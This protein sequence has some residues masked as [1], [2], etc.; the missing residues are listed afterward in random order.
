MLDGLDGDYTVGHGRSYLRML[1]SAGRWNEFVEQVVRTSRLHEQADHRQPQDQLLSSPGAMLR[2]FALRELDEL[3]EAGR[4]LPVF[5]A[6][7]VLAR[8]TDLPA[9]FYLKRYLRKLIVPHRVHTLKKRM[10]GERTSSAPDLI[11]DSFALRVGLD[12]R[13]S[14]AG[15]TFEGDGR[16]E[17]RA[18]LSS[19]GFSRGL[20]IADHYAAAHGIEL[21]HPF[22]DKRLVEFCLA[23]PLSQSFR[24]GWTRW[25]MRK[26]MEKVA[27]Q[28]ISWRIGKAN[29]RPGFVYGVLNHDAGRLREALTSGSMLDGFA[30]LEAARELFDRRDELGIVELVALCRAATVSSLLKAKSLSAIRVR[31]E[32]TS[33]FDNDLSGNERGRADGRENSEFSGMMVGDELSAVAVAE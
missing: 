29:L 18:L 23:L 24:N 1:A 9:S 33:D 26:S 7:R 11:A 32:V 8:G 28:K 31:D 22:L 4:W 3:A 20:E 13:T 19:D 5:K 25:I 21:R 30:D 27:P 17:Q 12:R 14:T 6:I 10:R 16:D 15:R 2:A